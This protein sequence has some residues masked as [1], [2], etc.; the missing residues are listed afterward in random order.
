MAADKQKGR[1]TVEIGLAVPDEHIGH[2]E[3][4]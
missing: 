1:L 2:P 3:E 4:D